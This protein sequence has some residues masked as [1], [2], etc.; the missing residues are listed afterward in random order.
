MYIHLFDQESSYFRTGGPDGPAPLPVCLAL[1]SIH[2][3]F[4]QD[5][6]LNR[7]DIFKQNRS[8]FGQ[9]QELSKWRSVCDGY[10]WFALTSDVTNLDGYAEQLVRLAQLELG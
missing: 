8:A 9:Q 1:G 4:N 5:R 7:R 3:H 2:N 6:H 10:V